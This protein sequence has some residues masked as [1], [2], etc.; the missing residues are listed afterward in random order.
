M[1]KLPL[2]LLLTVFAALLCRAEGGYAI[3]ARMLWL[4][5]AEFAGFYQA[6]ADRLYEKA[7]L[8][9]VISHPAPDEEIFDTLQDGGA[10][11]IVGWPL[12][13]LRRSAAG[14]DIVNAGQLA[15]RSALMLI[16]RKSSGISRPQEMSNHRIGLWPSA[17]LQ[18]TLLSFLAHYNVKDYRV[19]PVYTSADLFLY[20]GVDVTVGVY[21]DEYYRIRA[22]GIDAGELETFYLNDLFPKLVDDGL[23]CK[24]N[25][26][27][28]DPAAYRRF[29]AAT[30][31]GWRRAFANPSRALEL[32][33]EE[34]RRANIPY[35][36]GH[37]RWMLE[38]MRLLIAPA[39]EANDGTFRRD[40]YDECMKLLNMTQAPI[41]Y[42]TFVPNGKGP[43]K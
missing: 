21:Y 36:R 25:T 12:S 39:G 4:P 13:A 27:E 14:E 29:L 34:C 20:G 18:S 1:P 31:E 41:S 9:V 33:E 30:L 43:V 6:R 22:A 8:D 26:Y 40:S 7:G 10:D 35:S 11:V 19:I 32:V 37:Q 42:E 16:A 15:Q 24:R 28:A 38:G 17:S 3:R 5:Q 23:Y 2:I